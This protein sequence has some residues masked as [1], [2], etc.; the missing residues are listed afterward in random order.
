LDNFLSHLIVIFVCVFWCIME[1]KAWGRKEHDMPSLSDIC[2]LSTSNE[3]VMYLLD[4]ELIENKIGQQCGRVTRYPH[5]SKTKV[6]TGLLI[7]EGPRRGNM[8]W[9]CNKHD[10][11]HRTGVFVGTLFEPLNIPLPDI[12]QTLY[13]SMLHIP[14]S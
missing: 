8:Y 13:L 3:V 1:R 12:I 7:I 9:R 2:R 4:N 6:C 11:Q 14:V 10:C 5:S